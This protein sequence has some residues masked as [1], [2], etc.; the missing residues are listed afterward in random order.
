MNRK[1]QVIL[2]NNGFNQEQVV[3]IISVSP[4]HAFNYLIP[5]GMAEVA[6][7]NHIKH[8][9][10]FSEIKK[11]K[12]EAVSILNKKTQNRLENITKI[13]VYKKIGSNQLIFGSIKEKDIIHWINK[14]TNLNIDKKQIKIDNLNKVSINHINIEFQQNIITNIKLCILPYSI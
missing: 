7:K 3:K 10:M 5:N 8:Y 1:I 6:T 2:K 11:R 4:G 14:Y 9:T 13:T 12:Q